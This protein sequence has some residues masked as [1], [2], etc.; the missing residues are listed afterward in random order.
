MRDLPDPRIETR[1]P[2]LQADSLPSET[3]GKLQKTDKTFLIVQYSKKY[4][5]T[6]GIQGCIHIFESSQLEGSYV[7]DLLYIKDLDSTTTTTTKRV[8]NWI[9]NSVDII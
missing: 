6:A 3:S 9:N 5:T 4:S 1:S 7:G 8:T 2:A